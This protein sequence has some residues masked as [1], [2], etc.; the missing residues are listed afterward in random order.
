M[1]TSA[2]D[3]MLQRQKRAGPPAGLGVRQRT[4]HDRIRP[5]KVDVF[6]HAQACGERCR[7]ECSMLRQTVLRQTITISPG[8]TS[9]TN[10]PPAAVHGAALAGNGSA[11]TIGQLADAQRAE[12]VA[13]RARRSAWRGLITTREYAPFDV[14]PSCGSTAMLDAVGGQQ[15]A[16]G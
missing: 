4:V 14:C 15:A 16:R 10:S 6:K 1:T 3:G 9:R 5:G 11:G 7:S 8:S 13:G 2:C 12:A